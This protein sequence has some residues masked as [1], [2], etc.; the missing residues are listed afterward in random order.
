MTSVCMSVSLCV[1]GVW[2]VAL[3]SP[4]LYQNVFLLLWPEPL[5]FLPAWAEILLLCVAVTQGEDGEGL[6]RMCWVAARGT[7]GG[8]VHEAPLFLRRYLHDESA[9]E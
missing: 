2:G 7:P 9:F 4:P 8:S 5:P 1:W 6:R 3:P